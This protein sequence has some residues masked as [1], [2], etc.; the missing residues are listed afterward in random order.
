L[1]WR[2]SELYDGTRI[3]A[4]PQSH[5]TAYWLYCSPVCDVS[6]TDGEGKVRVFLEDNPGQFATY[7]GGSTPA[8][9]VATTNFSGRGRVGSGLAT[10][11]YYRSASDSTH[12]VFFYDTGEKLGMMGRENNDTTWKFNGERLTTYHLLDPGAFDTFEPANHHR[13]I[14]AFAG[15]THATFPG[16]HIAAT[17]F[18]M[19]VDG[20]PPGDGAILALQLENDGRL[21]A[22]YW[23]P[24]AGKWTFGGPIQFAGGP[25]PAP[26]FKSIAMNVKRKFYGIVDGAILEY[27]IDNDKITRFVFLRNLTEIL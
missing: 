6:E 20:T 9:W 13:P 3:Q 23:D 15:S 24:R 27:L 8:A 12:M 10:T 7:I 18:Y 5:L 26:A 17:S 4:Q 11:P 16:Q 2:Q 22:T 19:E 14:D 21:A 1:F 25:Q